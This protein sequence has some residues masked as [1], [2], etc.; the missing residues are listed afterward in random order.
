VSCAADTAVEE[1]DAGPPGADERTGESMFAVHGTIA[2]GG[3]L[4]F[5]VLP[6]GPLSGKSKEIMGN[7]KKSIGITIVIF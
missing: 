1:D 7:H 2:G 5:G 6:M 4:S 3:G